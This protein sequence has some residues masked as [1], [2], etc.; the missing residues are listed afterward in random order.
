[1]PSVL[2]QKVA[3][4][5][6]PDRSFA[7]AAI[8]K[9]TY[10]FSAEK[11]STLSLADAQT[12]LREQPLL[13]MDGISE[14]LDDSD[15]VPQ[16]P[17]TDVVVLGSAHAP[18][19]AK[20]I[21]VSVAVGKMA[22]RL[23]VLGPRHAEVRPD[24]TVR[25]TPTGTI[26]HLPLSAR[27]AYGG[28]DAWAQARLA[29]P[30]KTLA[31]SM[32]EPVTGLFAYARNSIGKGFYIDCDR[33][34]VDGEL[35]PQIED[36]SDPLLPDRFFVP[37]PEAWIDAPI[38]ASIGWVHYTSYPR[39]YRLV[40]SLLHFR[41]PE[42]PIREA[43]FPDGEDLQKP[44]TPS[45][46]GVLPRSL[47]GAA[48][49]LACERLRGNELVILENLSPKAPRIELTLPGEWPQI[50]VRPPDVK[51]FQPEPVL[52]TLRI[53]PDE[54]RLSLTFCATIPLLAPISSL[55][56]ERVELGVS[57]KKL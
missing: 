25:F 53:E 44:W 45:G 49:G 26:T 42:R 17:A 50:I 3:L 32:S 24:G 14:L 5:R 22:R 12:P 47:Q 35:L 28:Y 27:H 13:Q 36:P 2:T 8:V 56:L 40:G 15:L 18:N 48:P 21:L 55:F 31:S 46:T 43:S 29:P 51:A 1:M 30:S 37:N 7:L 19:G 33:S 41:E 38:A 23:S 52:Q 4:V 6:N 34:R 54:E 10:S 16:K 57:W 39:M 9:R 11:R 20:E